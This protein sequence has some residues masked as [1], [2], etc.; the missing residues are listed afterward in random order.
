MRSSRRVGFAHF[1]WFAVVLVSAG[2]A[3]ADDRG[4]VDRVLRDEAGEHKFT[5]FVPHDYSPERAWPVILFLHGAGER[6]TDGKA[7][8]AVGLGPAIRSREKSFPFIAVFPQCEDRDAPARRGWLPETADGRRALAILAAVEREFRTD[9]DR[10]VLTGLSMGGF[11]TWAHAAADPARWAAIVPICGGGDPAWATSGKIARLPVWCFHGADDRVVPAAES[12]A[13]IDALKKAG[14]APKYSE[15]A[16]IAHNSWD[17]AFATNELYTWLLSH[18]RGE[19]T[20]AP[21]SRG[22]ARPRPSDTAIETALPDAPFVSALEI[23][24]AVFVRLGNDALAAVA[25]SLPEIVPADLLAGTVPDAQQTTSSE[26]MTFTVQLRGISYRGQI[27]RA[28]IEGRG[29]NRVAVLLG[30]RNVNL[31]INRTNISGE[32]RSATC[33]PLKIVLGHRAELPIRIEVE[34]Q[35]VD[36]RLKFKLLTTQFRLSR[37]N[38]TVGAPEWVRASGLGM[39]EDRV[40]ESLRSGLYNDP[41]RIERELI[42]AVPRMLEGLEKQFQFEPLDRAVAGLWPLPVYRPRVRTWPAE[43]RSD[44][45]GA[46]IWFGVSVAAIS[47]DQAAAGPKTAEI[48]A[49]E[50]SGLSDEHQLQFGLA[51]QLIEPLSALVVAADAARVHVT[52]LP[53]KQLAALADPRVLA[54]I[55]PDLKRRGNVEVRCEVVVTEPMRLHR[56]DAPT[57][58]VLEFELPKIKLLVAVR[59]A[60]P[61]EKAANDWTPFLDID[62]SIRHAAR[63]EI[64]SPTPSRRAL[65]LAWQGD[66]A[67][68]VHARFAPNAAPADEHIDTAR[69]REIIAAGWREWTE[70]GPLAQAP[71]DDIDLGFAKLRASA[72]GWADGLLVTTFGPAAIDVHNRTDEPVTYEVKGPYSDW[73]EPITLDA[74]KDHRYGVAY[75]MRVRIKV[76]GRETRYVLQPGLRYEFLT[77]E[78]DL[79]LYASREE[80]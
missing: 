41:G 42:A 26:G 15:L 14:A 20:A 58:A 36:R 35:V 19:K 12:R 27:S 31:I 18:K 17:A 47:D 16:G 77:A 68:E 40:S 45:G 46:T 3:S 72:V 37:D 25:D 80:P 21:D 34:P 11:G 10:V 63:P 1:A 43:V 13:M 60:Q 55:A 54:E 7:Q 65:A 9:K 8:V 52:D 30:L 24:R 53:M 61:A 59:P 44:S 74:G 70:S 50:V 32:G 56:S 75:P 4:F 78:G 79:E 67:I 71:L 22:P 48:S 29:D 2:L 69:I 62:V 6:G 51:T 28:T 64:A 38:W 76:K 49:A 73:S 23:P 33:G 5:V 66:A 57:G 39:S